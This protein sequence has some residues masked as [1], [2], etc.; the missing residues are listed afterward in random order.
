MSTLKLTA[1]PLTREGFAAFGDVI[2]VAGADHF[3][4]NEGRVERYHD[5]AAVAIDVD[6]GGRPL[7][8]IFKANEK[9]TLPAQVRVVERH[10][11]GSQAFI[12]MHAEPMVVVVAPAGEGVRPQDL[13]AFISNG[14]QGVNYHTG[15]WH[16]PLIASEVGQQSLVVD[17][18]GPGDNCDELYLEDEV[19]FVDVA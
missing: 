16:M 11:R 18:G 5:L 17:R 13:R 10:P 15:V 1:M 19:I 12:P 8:S 3:P 2:E 6:T 9:T 14:Q 7:I 4:I